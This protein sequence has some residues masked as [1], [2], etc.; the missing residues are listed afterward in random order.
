MSNIL[1][2]GP[3]GQLCVQ[4]HFG[5]VEP[6]NPSGHQ[7]FTFL[8]KHSFGS[9]RC[10]F[11]L[12]WSSIVFLHVRLKINTWHSKSFNHKHFPRMIA[13][14]SCMFHASIP[15]SSAKDF[16]AASV[17]SRSWTLGIGSD[18]FPPVLEPGGP[19]MGDVEVITGGPHLKRDLPCVWDAW[20]GH[21][22]ANCL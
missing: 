17:S 13:H 21:M 11:Q 8:L 9:D 3:Y 15:T 20:E 12:I 6:L 7:Q 1:H 16:F 5:G 2:W 10:C 19:S 4:P 14:F 22:F 18:F